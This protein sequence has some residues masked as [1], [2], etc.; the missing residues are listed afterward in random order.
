M[1]TRV[2]NFPLPRGAHE[3]GSSFWLSYIYSFQMFP[4]SFIYLKSEPR[5]RQ[6]Q[7]IVGANTHRVTLEDHKSLDFE[8]RH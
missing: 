5:L 1:I 7:D 8:K 4:L 6:I 2:I 3:M